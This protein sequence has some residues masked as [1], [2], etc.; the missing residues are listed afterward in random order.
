MPQLRPLRLLVVRAA[1]DAVAADLL[2]R[3]LSL[4]IRRERLLLID[5]ALLAV[6]AASEADYQTMLAERTDTAIFVLSANFLACSSCLDLLDILT[7]KE[8]YTC[9]PLRYS[10]CTLTDLTALTRLQSLPRS[11]PFVTEYSRS[12]EA[13][14]SI[15][16]DISNLVKTKG[17]QLSPLREI[18][19]MHTHN[20]NLNSSP[21]L[22]AREQVASNRLAEVLEQLL[23]ASEAKTDA[24][25]ELILLKGQFQQLDFQ[26]KNGLIAAS[27]ANV[28]LANIRHSLLVLITRVYE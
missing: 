18:T 15:A 14:A 24:N 11:G 25:T 12:D 2:R 1:E 5:A 6:E 20:N 7:A 17:P 10:T 19:P 8:Q 26:Q 23:D 9:L 4:E 3:H 27:D 22:L 21:A 16:S 13:W 28:A